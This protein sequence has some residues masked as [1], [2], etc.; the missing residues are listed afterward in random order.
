NLRLLGREEG[1]GSQPTIQETIA[2][3]R[4]EIDLGSSVYS[5]D[6]LDLLERKLAEYELFLERM[7]SH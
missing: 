3:L 5:E 4:R 1:P 7:L 6:E 2:A